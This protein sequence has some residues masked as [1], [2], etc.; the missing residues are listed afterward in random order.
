MIKYSNFS[1][2]VD[3][4]SSDENVASTSIIGDN[5]LKIIRRDGSELTTCSSSEG[6][7]RAQDV[8]QLLAKDNADFVLHTQKDPFI[9]GDV[10]DLLEM[11]KKVIGGYGDIFRIIRQGYN[12]P[13]VAPE[14]RFITRGLRQHTKVS[15]VRRL[16]NKRYEI[17]RHSL[18]TVIIIA[19]GDYDLAVESVRDAL[20]K[21]KP[22][23][24]VYKSN[25][26]GR[27][28]RSA[29]EFADSHQ[30]K[31]LSWKELLGKLNQAWTSR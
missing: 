17:S 26:N 13:Y 27:T 6:F 18:P 7:F 15:N 24:A 14:E 11:R 30:F 1:W 12:W 19:L 28:S 20:D 21:Y 2:L 22:F 4:L 3:K 9:D 10:F 29:I 8:L 23:D 25:P 16:D 31:I 5:L